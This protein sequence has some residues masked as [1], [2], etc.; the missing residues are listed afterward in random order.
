MHDRHEIADE[1]FRFSEPYGIIGTNVVPLKGVPGRRFCTF[2]LAV[3][4]SFSTRFSENWSSRFFGTVC[5][6]KNTRKHDNDFPFFAIIG[7]KHRWRL[8]AP[9]N[10]LIEKSGCRVYVNHT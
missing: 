2:R 3:L 4:R 9:Q 8:R 1:A 6:A 10:Q 5:L 7:L